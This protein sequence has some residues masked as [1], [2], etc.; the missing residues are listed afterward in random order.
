VSNFIAGVQI[1]ITQPIRLHDGVFLE[2]E[3]GVVEEITTTY[4]I[5][6]LWDWRRMDL[7]LSYF[8]E[9]PFQNW[10]RETSA[11]IG[12][13]FLYLDYT[14]PVEKL[15]AKLMEIAHA[16]PLWDGGVVVLQV[17]DA[18][19]RTLELRALISA[20]SVMAAWD[21]RCE[22]RERLIAY[23][24]AE[25]PEALPRTRAEVVDGSM[26]RRAKSPAHAFV[27]ES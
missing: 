13:V 24:Q 8:I 26:A 12:A 25:Y 9:K 27:P 19:E 4:V 21:L 6:K 10:T 2:G 14:A 18:K 22:V 1:A 5:V 7:P 3:Y 20:R 15:R 11:L 16:S 17:S 23:M